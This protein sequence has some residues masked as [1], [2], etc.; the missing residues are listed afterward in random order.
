[1]LYFGIDRPS[2][3]Y[4]DK[5]IKAITPPKTHMI[6]AAAT[7]S[8]PRM[9]VPGVENI[10]LPRRTYSVQSPDNG[11]HGTTIHRSCGSRSNTSPRKFPT[12]D[13]S[14]CLLPTHRDSLRPRGEARSLPHRAPG[15][16]LRHAIQGYGPARALTC[17]TGELISFF[18]QKR[19]VDSIRLK[20]SH[21]PV[22][23]TNIMWKTIRVLPLIPASLSRCRIRYVHTF[24]I[25]TPTVARQHFGQAR[26]S[27][28]L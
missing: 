1:M 8:V 14:G 27:F 7:L 16:A 12:S 9:M 20:T 3:K 17:C 25:A 23:P 13:R 21:L 26:F 18:G 5:E 15:H 6:S 19:D 2:S 22:G 10:P 4:I 24:T 28:V 11:G